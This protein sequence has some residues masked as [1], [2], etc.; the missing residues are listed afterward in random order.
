MHLNSSPAFAVNCF[1]SSGLAGLCCI[2]T[3]LLRFS[4]L[5]PSCQTQKRYHAMLPLGLHCRDF[6][7]GGLNLLRHLVVL[8]KAMWC[9]WALSDLDFRCWM[10]I[11]GVTWSTSQVLEDAINQTKKCGLDVADCHALPCLRDIDTA[12]VSPCACCRRWSRAK[13]LPPKSNTPSS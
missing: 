4:M 2:L 11:Q 8:G 9:S 13:R 5:V 6:V 3:Q 7:L 1:G 10:F 12:E